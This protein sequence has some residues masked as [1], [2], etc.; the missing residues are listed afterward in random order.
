MLE[1]RLA[2]RFEEEVGFGAGGVFGVGVGEGAGSGSPGSGVGVGG[3]VWATTL[4]SR[5]VVDIF[6][7][8]LLV[9]Q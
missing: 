3:G 2:D 9:V 5:I 8:L 6:K 4:L 7:P 1:I